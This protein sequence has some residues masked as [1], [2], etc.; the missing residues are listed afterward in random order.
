MIPVHSTTLQV[1]TP[2]EIARRLNGGSAEMLRDE[3]PDPSAPGRL[4]HAAVL[5]PLVV[6][7]GAWSVLLTARTEFVEDH[8]GQVSFPG[9]ACEPGDEGPESAALR[10]AREEIGLPVEKAKILGH[11]PRYH[12]ISNFLVNPV[13]AEVAWPFPIKLEECEVRRA[14]TVPLEFLARPGNHGEREVEIR[15]QMR[16]VLFFEPYDGEVLWGISARIML[17]LLRRLDLVA[18]E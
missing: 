9:G 6:E 17:E 4:R 3:I 13:V 10:E 15:G 14:F 18:P 8:K 7:Q 12:T 2:E 16:R 1:L 5:V 11:L